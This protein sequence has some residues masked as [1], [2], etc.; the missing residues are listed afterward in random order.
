[1]Q[2]N[3]AAPGKDERGANRFESE[4]HNHRFVCGE[5]LGV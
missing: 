5:R 4:I 3:G 2:A 1:M